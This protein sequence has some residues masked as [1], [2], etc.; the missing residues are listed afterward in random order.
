ML[1]YQSGQLLRLQ[2]IPNPEDLDYVFLRESRSLV[3]YDKAC[4]TGGVELEV[5]YLCGHRESLVHLLKE[6][7]TL[8]SLGK[9]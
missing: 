3:L 9:Y 5:F 1:S 7:G 2:S 4:G 6:K 8:D